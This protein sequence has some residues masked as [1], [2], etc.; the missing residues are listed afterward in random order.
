MSVPSTSSL[1]VCGVT[2]PHSRLR[3]VDLP[4]ARRADQQ[5]ALLLRGGRSS[6]I[7]SENAR[8]PGQR[9]RT[10]DIETTSGA[11]RLG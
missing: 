3:N 7:A 1:P 10:P 2:M 9:K 6:S 4:A 8:G 5:H 11:W